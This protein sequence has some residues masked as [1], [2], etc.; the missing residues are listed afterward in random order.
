MTVRTALPLFLC[1]LGVPQLLA[2]EWP[3]WRGPRGD[4]TSAET[5]VP[6]KWGKDENVRWRTA[7]P[8]LGHSSPIVWG[9]RVF[10]TSCLENEEKRLLLCLHR[11]DGKVLW[12]RVVLTAKLEHK[13][14]L[15]SFASGTP[16]TDGKHVWVAFLE[17][18]NMQVV[19]YDY[20][21]NKAWQR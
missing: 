9:D 12:E 5:N 11:R 10:V 3:G 8:G 18:P 4:G 14:K 13:H 2:E 6:V 1:L 20:E 16:V 15:N 21:G 19:C 7:I 17:Y